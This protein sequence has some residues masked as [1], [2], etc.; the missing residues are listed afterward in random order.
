MHTAPILTDAIRF[1]QGLFEDLPSVRIRPVRASDKVAIAAMVAGL[2]MQTRQYRFFYPLHTLPEKILERFTHADPQSEMTL[3]AYTI[4]NGAET[5]V[6]MANYVVEQA[7]RR[8]EY[9]VV[10]DD[11]WQGHG[12]ARRLLRALEEQ[13]RKAKLDCLFGE[14]MNDNLPMVAF[15]RKEGFSFGKH[16]DDASLRVSWKSIRPA[17]ALQ[18]FDMERADCACHGA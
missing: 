14:I 4:V 15:A 10:V 13:A 18:G 16:P 1:V 17:F 11:H 5:L 9:A 6:G 7:G 12:I 8:A 3:L 2:S